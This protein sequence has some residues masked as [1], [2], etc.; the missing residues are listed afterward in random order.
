MRLQER[1]EG[2]RRFPG[3]E[4]PRH[5]WVGWAMSQRNWKRQLAKIGAIHKSLDSEALRC[6]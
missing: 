6:R 1:I 5:M 2:I 4:V 3:F